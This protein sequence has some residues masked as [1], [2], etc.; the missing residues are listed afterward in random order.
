MDDGDGQ[1]RLILPFAD[2]LGVRCVASF[3]MNG[4]LDPGASHD[5]P[6]G[7]QLR[8]SVRRQSCLA[9][10]ETIPIFAVNRRTHSAR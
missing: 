5:V 2:G 10:A 6:D 9:L 1:N 8:A 3:D 7:S 4:K